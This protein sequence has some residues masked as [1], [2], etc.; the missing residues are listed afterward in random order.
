MAINKKLTLNDVTYDLMDIIA[1]IGTH[2]SFQTLVSNESM[3]TSSSVQ[4][5]K[6]FIVGVIAPDNPITFIPIRSIKQ[7]IK[8]A[9]M[10][11][12]KE[13][14]KPTKSAKGGGGGARVVPKQTKSVTI[15][16]LR[17][18]LRNAYTKR[19]GGTPPTEKQLALMVAQC[20]QE[21]SGGRSPKSGSSTIHP[22]NFNMFGGHDTG[23]IPPTYVATRVEDM[24]GFEDL[25]IQI[26][27][28]YHFKDD[29]GNVWGPKGEILRTADGRALNDGTIGLLRDGYLYFAPVNGKS[30]LE[31]SGVRS[32]GPAEKFYQQVNRPGTRFLGTDTEGGRAYVSCYKAFNSLEEA[33]DWYVGYIYNTFPGIKTAET[34]ED[35]EEAIMNGVGGTHFHDNSKRK[36]PAT[37]RTVSEDYVEGLRRNSEAY[38]EIYGDSSISGGRSSGNTSDPTQRIM[39]YGSSYTPDDPLADVYGR[40]IEA[41]TTRLALLNTR[42]NSLR[43]QLQI[44]RQIPPLILLVNPQ[45]FRRSHDNIVDYGNKTRTGNVVHT[46]LEQPIKITASGVTASQ[47]AVYADMSGGLTNYS[48]IHSLSYRNL[49]SLLMIYKNNG[50]LY[51]T[52]SPSTDPDTGEPSQLGIASD[53][54]IILPGA[55]FIYYDEHVYIGSFDSFSITDDAAKPYN[56]SYSFTFTTR[57]DIHIDISTITMSSMES[58]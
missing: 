52:A 8:K 16:A 15:D 17:T 48:R 19:N 13:T 50:M 46:H 44:M 2:P 12:P 20:L 4:N 26:S 18:A 5:W 30:S 14:T 56:L 7:D 32:N 3:I 29:K 10:P 35:W 57:Y 54:S 45:E 31:S 38:A 33:V 36:D 9:D 34:P 6:P 55:I 41:D 37:G 1:G 28:P 40:N 25:N 39:T 42:I 49:M 47:Y 58:M 53:S 23:V 24:Q 21:T 22:P 11:P 51:D 27:V 43:A